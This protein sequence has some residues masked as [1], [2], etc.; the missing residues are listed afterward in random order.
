MVD[1][2]CLCFSVIDEGLVRKYGLYSERIPQ[3]HLRLADGSKAIGITQIAHIKLDV[4]GRIEQIWGYVMPNLSFPIILGK[5]W[6]EYND[7]VYS[8]KRRTLRIG[9][10][11]HGMLV[12]ASGWYEREAP[13]KVRTRIASVSSDQ[14]RQISRGEMLKMVAQR[15]KR[16]ELIIG[17][18]SMHDIT[19]ALE[20]KKILSYEEI[21]KRLLREVK[22]YTN[23]F[24]DDN[25]RDGSALPPHRP[26][27]T[28]WLSL[29]KMT[30]VE[31][32]R[33]LGVPYMECRARNF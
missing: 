6:M 18:V 11:K 30:G 3:R 15:P 17:I 2:G 1:T 16:N 26:G 21:K 9:S 13:E 27:W 7:V 8:A 22:K 10:R 4:D 19:Q 20:P 32:W 23:L 24:V 5:P 12:R 14:L 28:P 31:N 29:F 33:Y 25:L